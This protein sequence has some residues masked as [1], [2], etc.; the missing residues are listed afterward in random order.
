MTRWIWT[1]IL[2]CAGLV[3]LAALVLWASGGFGELG[4]SGNG[5][6]ALTLGT[7]FTAAL[8]IGLMALVFFSD[9]SGRDEEADR[10]GK[11]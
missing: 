3:G 9:R 5:V 2:A 11:R 7:L 1:F 8:A 10:A 6:I 4:L